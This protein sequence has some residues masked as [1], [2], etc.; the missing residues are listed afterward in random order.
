MIQYEIPQALQQQIDEAKDWRILY[1]LYFD[2]KVTRANGRKVP[3]EH[4]VEK[5]DIEDLQNLLQYLKIPFLPEI[6]KRHP[7]DYF[8]MGRM[9]YK[10]EDNG[11]LFNKDVP[12]SKKFSN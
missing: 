2:K 5:P 4:A 8:V 12:N 7:R 3:L 9:R 6:N 11:V 1:P 10:L